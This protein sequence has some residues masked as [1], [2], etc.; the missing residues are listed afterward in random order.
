MRVADLIAV[1]MQLPPGMQV[2]VPRAP[3]DRDGA[4]G[5]IGWVLVDENVNVVLTDH[6]DWRDLDRDRVVH[7]E[8]ADD[9]EHAKERAAEKRADGW[10]PKRFP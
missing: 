10:E 8:D 6:R 5:P 7:C 1:L 9:L 4:V 2:H 3:W